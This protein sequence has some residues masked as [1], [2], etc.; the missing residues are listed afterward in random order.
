MPDTPSSPSSETPSVSI[1]FTRYNESDTYVIENLIAL[2]GQKGVSGEILFLDQADS[3]GIEGFINR[4]DF[5]PF[6]MRRLDCPQKGLSFARNL[7]IEKANHDIVI[8]IDTDAVAAPDWAQ[9]L[10]D[11]LLQGEADGVAVAGGKILLRW[12]HQPFWLAN[13]K[14]V[15]DIYGHFDLGDDR[16]QVGLVRG[17]S[18]AI[19]RR[20]TPRLEDGSCFDLSYGRID[21]KLV[22]GEES[23]LCLR[24]VK[25]GFKVVYDGR[26]IMEHQVQPDRLSWIWV[27]RRLYHGGWGRARLGGLPGVGSKRKLSQYLY[28]PFIVP[29]YALG[30]FAG[31]WADMKSG[32]QKGQHE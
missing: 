15:A 7:G 16:Q 22:S 20:L 3:T 31:K 29:P 12:P 9:W 17:G 26:S 21:G 8:F 23:E 18:L 32:R 1:V 10:A 5:S 14:P 13:A 19:N 11:A 28:F 2:A 6:Q 24:T 30:Y 27:W 25:S 4:Y